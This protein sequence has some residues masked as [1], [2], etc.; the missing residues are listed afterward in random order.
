MAATRSMAA[1]KTERRSNLAR[2]FSPR[3]I[4][5]IGGDEAAE[6]ARQC[7]TI[8][9]GGQMWAVNP[10][11]SNLAGLPCLASV[12][13]LPEPPD[14]CFLAVPSKTTV[15]ILG[16]L[17]K[18]G[19]GGV[20]CYA[21]GFREIGSNGEQLER[22]LIEAAG[23]MAL[24]G[25][26]CYGVLN[27][28]KGIAL[29]PYGQPGR[30]VERGAAMITQSGMFAIN[31]TFSQRSAGFSHIISAGNQSVLGIEDYIDFLLDD[32]A[33]VAIGLHIEMLR[34]VSKF[35][36]VALQ[37]VHRGIP[38][39]AFKTG[40]S[41]IGSHLTMSHTGSLAG[42]DDVYNALFDRLAITRVDTPAQLIETLKMFTL[43]GVP[44]GPRL[45]AFTCSGGD[46]EMVADWA[47]RFGVSLP[48]PS[49]AVR[50]QL[51]SQLGP[52]ATVSNPLDYN[53]AIWGN[54]Q[55][56][57]AAHATFLEQGFDAAVLIQDYPPLNSDIDRVGNLADIR[58]F[59]TAARSAGVPAA[60]CST[61]PECLT[62]D[63]RDL[64][65]AHSAAPLQGIRDGLFAI[66]AAAGY[67]ARRRALIAAG[68]GHHELVELPPASPYSPR[69]LD[70]WEGKQFVAAIGVPI[71][72]GRLCCEADAPAAASAIGF[73]VAVKL[74]SAGLPHKTEA[75]VVKLGIPDPAALRN[76]I[77]DI[78]RSAAAHFGSAC[79]DS[80]LV[81]RMASKPVAE[82]MV[83]VRRDSQFGFVLVVGAGGTQVEV[84]RD[85]VTLLL[86]ASR[87]DV[88]A[89][90]GRL[91]IAPILAGHRG[92]PAGDVDAYCDTVLELA[93]LALSHAANL[94]E[95]ELNPVMVLP[96]GSG[97]VAVDAL[98]RLADGRS[99]QNQ[100]PPYG[101]TGA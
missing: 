12:E 35:A 78:K 98:L 95:L 50:E 58:G 32:P 23:S 68:A 70:E 72:A 11:R 25:P 86:P 40:A 52:F 65:I 3:H 17:A 49:E 85:L 90:I 55:R 16:K 71:P 51:S 61:I 42:S 24:V 29:W 92:Q 9:F 96:R 2:L 60:V 100:P 91:R 94:Y 76:A 18:R 80:F 69:L 1:R 73:P 97:I 66:S 13:D 57:A 4:A 36:R 59:L 26:N 8:G 93:A 84:N 47:E 62:E 82:M 31:L 10:K 37:A 48:Q 75:G 30:L 27:Y 79:P 87:E 38:I 33:V 83:G 44:K 28:V 53:T 21:A 34:N 101:Q 54:E 39:V 6:A 7:R 64:V 88:A 89:A 99:P 67:G 45:A 43:G 77:Q 56:V 15:D 63:V 41:Q 46:S 74:I 5:F 20:V 81:E 14:A 19:A 22:A